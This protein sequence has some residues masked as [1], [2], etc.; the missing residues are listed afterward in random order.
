VVKRFSASCLPIAAGAIA[1]LA[2]PGAAPVS[3]AVE[4]ASGEPAS[5]VPKFDIRSSTWMRSN[6]RDTPISAPR[7]EAVF[8]SPTTRCPVR[9]CEAPNIN[10]P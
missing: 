4:A 6:C 5:S 2:S 10:E 3:L 1:S 8:S 9:T 7:N